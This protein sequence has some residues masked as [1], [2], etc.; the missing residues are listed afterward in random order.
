MMGQLSAAC[1]H[2]H[3]VRLFQKQLLQ[4]IAPAGDYSIM[5]S[6]RWYRLPGNGWHFGLVG[7]ARQ[8]LGWHIIRILFLGWWL[9]IGQPEWSR[10]ALSHTLQPSLP[11]DFTISMPLVCA[12]VERAWA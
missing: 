2:S 5:D 12:V 6:S 7:I 10:S 3:F 9:K 1:S 8:V 11:S 4:V